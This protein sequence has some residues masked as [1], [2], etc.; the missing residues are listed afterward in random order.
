MSDKK[1]MQVDANPT[2]EFFIYM[3]TRDIETKAAIVELI[4]NSI[5]GAKKIRKNNDY[6]GLKINIEF[7]K[8]HF[9][10]KDN[11][12]GFDIETA[13][14]YAFKFGRPADRESEK[15]FYTGLFGIGMKRAL[16][17]LG[18]GFTVTSTTAST[19]FTIVVDVEEWKK[20][21]EWFFPMYDVVENGSFS[22]SEQGTS[23]TID[24]LYPEQSSNFS[25]R[26]FENMLFSYVEKYRSVE[27]EN[28]L[29]IQINRKVV[30]FFKEKL[31]ENEN[32]KCY[33]NYIKTE[34]G[35]IRII[36]GIAHNGIPENAG[37]YVFC[38][39]RLVLFADK[40]NNTGWGVEY[41]GYHPS[42]ASFRGYVYFESESLFD[43]PFQ[44]ILFAFENC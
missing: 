23:I 33:R 39:G 36:A 16:F 15:G 7:N 3:I 13:T 5:D 38:N 11:C 18:G 8:D 17:K 10:I 6:R 26:A 43:L 4:D 12:G 41:R 22:E 21:P 25:N 29:E 44:T 35:K 28:G 27:A 32:V 42:L 1:T 40:T 9:I 19:K 37:W 14:K 20:N 34:T 24:K 2:K 30:S 31:I